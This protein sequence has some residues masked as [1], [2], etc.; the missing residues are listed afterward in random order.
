MEGRQPYHI[1]ILRTNVVVSAAG[2]NENIYQ[3]IAPVKVAG[4]A[5]YAYDVCAPAATCMLKCVC[6]FMCGWLRVKCCAC[7]CLSVYSSSTLNE[8]NALHLDSTRKLFH[9][10]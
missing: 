8:A 3:V 5:G 6:R 10:F 2:A 9:C 4:S 7:C 1:Y